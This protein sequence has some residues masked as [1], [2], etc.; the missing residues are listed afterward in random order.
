MAQPVRPLAA[1][2]RWCGGVGGADWF[3]GMTWAASLALWG[4]VAMLTGHWALHF[5]G[6]RMQVSG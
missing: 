2:W 6:Q 1:L 5:V 3:S 4:L